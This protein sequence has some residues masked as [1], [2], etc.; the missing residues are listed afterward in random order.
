[1]EGS[2]TEHA[3]FAISDCALLTI[4]TGEHALNL[5][6]LAEGLREVELAS[7]YHHFWGRLLQPQFDEPEY[8]NDFASW[9]HHELHDK[10]VAE[11]LSAVDPVEY[12]DTEELRQELL[13]IVEMR[14]DE[15]EKAQ[16]DR[17]DQPFHFLRSQLIA[18][19]THHSIEH[20]RDLAA[21]IGGMNAGSIFYHFIDAR[22]RTL[23]HSNDFSVWLAGWDANFKS[24]SE[25]FEAIDPYFS[26][27]QHI[28]D[29]LVRI[30]DD[31]FA[32]QGNDE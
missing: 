32:E 16:Y 8:N 1:M 23:E 20:P 7:I 5:R 30:C 3:P 19:D 10:T 29:L 26:S 6:E 12:K 18:L 2:I 17:A 22:R 9:A 21:A 4:A 15:S 14:L 24:L 27:L 31:Y 11:R 25:H 28:R 13:E